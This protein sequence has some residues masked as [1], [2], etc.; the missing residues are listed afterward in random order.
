MKKRKN[1]WEIIKIVLILYLLIQ[2]FITI[3]QE[4][5]INELKNFDISQFQGISI[6]T[7]FGNF[8]LIFVLVLFFTLIKNLLVTLALI[9]ITI[10][11]QKYKKQ[12]LDK[13]DL[14]KYKGYYREILTE[15]NP[16]N[17]SF[18]DDFNVNNPETIIAEL[19]YLEKNGYVTKDNDKLIVNKKDE[20]LSE[21]ENYILDNINDGKLQITSTFNLETKIQQ[22]SA[23]QKIV[24]TQE[25]SKAELQKNNRTEAIICVVAWIIMFILFTITDGK[26]ISIKNDTLALILFI[27]LGIYMIGTVFLPFIMLATNIAYSIKFY[28]N[29]YIRT[30][31]GKELN[32]YME[33]LKNY[34]KDYSMLNEKTEEDITLWDEYLIY[35]V[36][37][38]QNKKIIEEYKNIVL[39]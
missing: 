32:M 12:K 37:F 26:T 3:F 2:T 14:K 27:I 22:D 34:L 1:I 28:M 6:I 38:G 33:G 10:G 39:F 24:K 31:K 17:L 19:L 23:K 29:P 21:A 25:T 8:I 13:N 15:Y 16:L 11:N 35:S 30:K 18:V 7:V 36:L 9:G 5:D 20:R 4:C